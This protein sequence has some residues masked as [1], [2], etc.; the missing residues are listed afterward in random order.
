MPT[1]NAGIYT[2]L[3][4]FYKCQRMDIVGHRAALG[5]RHIS[6]ERTRGKKIFLESSFSFA[7]AESNETLSTG[8]L[9]SDTH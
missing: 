9:A 2:S 6:A 3:L 4:I 5:S 7:N 8:A 1:P